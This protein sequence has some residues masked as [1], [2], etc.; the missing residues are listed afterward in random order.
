MT[1]TI[2]ARK[3]PRRARKPVRLRNDQVAQRAFLLKLLRFPA[4]C[5]CGSTNCSRTFFVS[6]EAYAEARREGRALM[7]HH[8]REPRD[9]SAR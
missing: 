4:V 7:A 5:E 9:R 1:T 3:P 8:S 2:K 6:L